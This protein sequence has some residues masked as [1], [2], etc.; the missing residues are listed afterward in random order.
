M[1]I[2]SSGMPQL[3][4]C[5][6]SGRYVPISPSYDP[7]EFVHFYNKK[8]HQKIM[9]FITIFLSLFFRILVFF[10]EK[11][12]NKSTLSTN[13]KRK[14]K[15]SLIQP[16]TSRSNFGKISLNFEKIGP[17]GGPEALRYGWILRKHLKK[18]QL[19]THEKIFDILNI[20][21]KVKNNTRKTHEI[22]FDFFLKRHILRLSGG[23]SC[24]HLP[25]QKSMCPSRI[26]SFRRSLP[27]LGTACNLH[28]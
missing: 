28:F 4:K 20:F 11:L 8:S 22:F 13:P 17:G 3:V 5:K 21:F 16:R 27:Q 24:W 1:F 10:F 26:C 14:L 19:W 15:N 12:R 9:T 2:S 23:V 7:N 18:P 6:I 25:Y